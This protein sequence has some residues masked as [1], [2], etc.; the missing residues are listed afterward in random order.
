M[1]AQTQYEPDEEQFKPISITII[2]ENQDEFDMIY[3]L[4]N[5]SAIVKTIEDYSR[6]DTEEVRKVLNA[7]GS[8]TFKGHEK[9]AG[10]LRSNV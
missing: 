4:F 1:K 9:L 5:D 3:Y 2:M 7:V 10:A 8:P 6:I